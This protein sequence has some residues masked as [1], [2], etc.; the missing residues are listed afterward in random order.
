MHSPAVVLD[1]GAMHS[2]VRGNGTNLR[3]TVGNEDVA[4]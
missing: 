2:D 3:I 1:A 4:G